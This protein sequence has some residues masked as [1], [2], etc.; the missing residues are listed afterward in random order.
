MA[1]KEPATPLLDIG[2]FGTVRV[3]VQGR[4]ITALL[5]R[6]AA[7]ILAILALR[8]GK[9]IERWRLAGMVWPESPDATALHN[10]RQTLTPLRNALGPAK[11]LVKAVSPRSIVL[12]QTNDVS[13]DVWQFDLAAEDAQPS[14]LQR[15]IDLYTNRLLIEC[16]E[17][18]AT[19]EREARAASFL[20]ACD[21]LGAHLLDKKQYAQAITIFQKAL[22]EDNFR[23]SACRAMMSALAGSG[24]VSAALDFCREFRNK[25]RKELNSDISPET[26]SLV[27]NLRNVTV[28]QGSEPPARRLP[29]SLT[30]LIGRQEE[31]KHIGAM[32]SRCRL[33]TL[34]GPGGVGK[35][36]L[37]VAIA[38]SVNSSLRDGV[39]FVDLAPLHD[40]NSLLT[41]IASALEI[42]EK[43]TQGILDTIT[44][45]IGDQEA[46]LVFDN[47]EHLE[48]QIAE[49]V[50]HLLSKSPK[51]HILATSRQ[52]LGVAG[53]FIF[54]VPTLSIPEPPKKKMTDA[55]VKDRIKTLTNS[56]AV[57]LFLDR[58]NL[59]PDTIS[60]EELETAGSICRTLDGLPLAIELA[61][62]RTRFLS[63]REIEA[64][65]T[66]RF[67]LLTNANRAMPRHRTLQASIEWSWDLLTADERNILMRLSAFRG[68]ATLETLQAIT[69]D[70]PTAQLMDTVHS[71][72]D[73]SLVNATRSGQ[74]TRFTI[75]ETIR[76]YAEQRLSDNGELHD[77]FD[78]HR[79]Y[80]LK[81]AE[82]SESVVGT[83]AETGNFEKFER[84]HDNFRK[85]L[86]WCR[87]RN[88]G[89]M[90]L[91]LAEALSRFRSTQGHLSE[92]R[93]Q[94][95]AALL[96]A[97]AD[98]P[99]SVVAGGHILAGW[100]ATI[101]K[102]CDGAIAHYE[103]ALPIFRELGDEVGVGKAL[104][105]MGCA[106]VSGRRYDEAQAA[107]E[108]SLEN[109]LSRGKTG[110][111][112][113][114]LTNLAEVSLLRNNLEE[115]RSY[116][117]R[118]FNGTYDKPFDE[119][120]TWGEAH[121]NFAIIEYREGNFE[122]ARTHAAESLRQFTAGKRLTDIPNALQLAAVSRASFDDWTGFATLFG[123]SEALA[124]AYGTEF[125]ETLVDLRPQVLPSAK[126]V[127]GS[128]AFE[129]A[130]RMGH[131]MDLNSAVEYATKRENVV[132]AA[133][134]DPTPEKAGIT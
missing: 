1:Q 49:V 43:A 53:E 30:R 55:E 6:R 48:P 35:T 134:H 22:A 39:R 63:L 21:L 69:P 56:E 90:R 67:A 17:P 132:R 93:E 97:P 91:R 14:S 3:A 20:N 92:N 96:T 128:S 133:I 104:I 120:E 37:S 64:K 7:L 12:E 70:I 113:M 45:E 85:A 29:V 95:E 126:R 117:D 103:K 11:D 36:R 41:T 76:Q 79:D 84:E 88:H 122:K 98:M 116:L 38:A 58:S 83:A 62:A 8:E 44:E 19:N 129:K 46:L 87:E 118:A 33:V 82:D 72:V 80:F 78:R 24:Q 23:E 100:T 110:G 112:P 2:L 102:D 57:R 86:A 52:S 119:F 124:D 99:K 81:L 15:A 51:L 10:L 74:E 111:I 50:E 66:D 75:L 89:E 77:V 106:Y 60:F 42:P 59:N 105:C 5:T 101:Q 123:A 27:R 107:F 34:T 54:A 31:I 13:V 94:I 73:R 18:F 32:L 115:A 109:V 40:A 121:F 4:D 130:Y 25:L 131:A 71:L 16:E 114:L 47:C 26:R 108:A 9:P 28:E 125:R 65:L 61:A 68:G 127:L